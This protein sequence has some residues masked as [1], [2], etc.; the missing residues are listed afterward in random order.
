M[1]R[2]TLL[3]MVQ[4][5]SRQIGDKERKGLDEDLRVQDIANLCI[6]TLESI[7]SRRTW[8]FQRDRLVL[9]A[10]VTDKVTIAIPEAVSRLERVSYQI[11]SRS[12]ELCYLLPEKFLEQ[13]S[14]QGPSTEAVAVPGGATIW[15]RNNSEPRYYTSFDETTVTL[16]AYNSETDP[17][18]IQ[19]SKVR[20]LA[21]V[22]LDT[23]GARLAGLP[24]DSWVPDIPTRMFP[25]WFWESVQNCYATIVDGADELSSREARRQYVKMLENEP[26][27]QRD[28]DYRRSNRGRNYSY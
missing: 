19:P 7:C 1:R 20:I 24:V 4:D 25:L 11:L 16:D 15:V 21:E 5:V 6:S 17:T 2:S 22:Q 23:A 27:T 10:T 3:E 28:D 9:P 8:E 26:K 14:L 18:G 13:V 12:T